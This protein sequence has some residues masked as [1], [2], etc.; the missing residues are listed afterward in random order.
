MKEEK[1]EERRE[2][3]IPKKWASENGG[4]MD[5]FKPKKKKKKKKKKYVVHTTTFS[6]SSSSS[7]S[8]PSQW[9]NAT[10]SAPQCQG[11]A[12]PLIDAVVCCR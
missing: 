7:I 2:S 10:F 6:P 12:H 5:V 11:R 9:G 1:S 3:M 8:F 4:W